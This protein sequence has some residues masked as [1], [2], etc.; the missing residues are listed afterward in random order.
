M[1]QG[2]GGLDIPTS[3]GSQFCHSAQERMISKKP[4]ARTNDRRITAEYKMVRGYLRI[5]NR[6]KTHSLVRLPLERSVRGRRPGPEMSLVSGC[7][8]VWQ[9]VQFKVHQVCTTLP[10]WYLWRPF[11]LPLHLVALQDFRLVETL[12]PDLKGLFDSRKLQPW[13]NLWMAPIPSRL[14]LIWTTEHPSLRIRV[15]PGWEATFFLRKQT[16]C[17]SP[18]MQIFP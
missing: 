1:I 5:Q 12:R 17:L 14:V 16:R 8:L 13:T 11:L 10:H 15:S 18:S 4:T 6:Y 3:S 7:V 9:W 2:K